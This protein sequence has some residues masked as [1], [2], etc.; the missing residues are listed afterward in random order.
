ML[1]LSALLPSQAAAYFSEFDHEH[2]TNDEA[3]L[4]TRDHA[5]G[6]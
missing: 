1:M 2:P 6:S 3:S 4:E 5:N